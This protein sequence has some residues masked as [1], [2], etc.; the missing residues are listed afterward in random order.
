MPSDTM[1]IHMSVLDELDLTNSDDKDFTSFDRPTS[2]DRPDGEHAPTSSLRH[3]E[4]QD[5]APD[6][7]S[8]RAPE[9]IRRARP[10]T[11]LKMR[12]CLRTFPTVIRVI[13]ITLITLI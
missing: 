13:I 7:G 4:G 9:N 12:T 3:P 2:L 11:Y 6:G 8:S 10:K 1:V 5:R